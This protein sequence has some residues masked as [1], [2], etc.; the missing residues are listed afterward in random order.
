MDSSLEH[1][2]AGAGAASGKGSQQL[3][4]SYWLLSQIGIALHPN[5]ASHRTMRHALCTVDGAVLLLGR[6]QVR[7]DA[8][9]G[10]WPPTAAVRTLPPAVLQLARGD[11]FKPFGV[12]AQRSIVDQQFG[13]S[14]SLA[15]T[16]GRSFKLVWEVGRCHFRVVM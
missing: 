15:N 3:S 16:P 14:A 10:L 1:G 8:P 9:L 12:A 11:S 7:H 2:A 6:G 4:D 5:S 13:P